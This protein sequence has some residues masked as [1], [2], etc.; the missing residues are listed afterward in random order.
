LTASSPLIA[1]AE[2]FAAAETASSEIDSFL[3]EI[4]TSFIPST[5]I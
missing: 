3:T 2:F 1:T 5:L 4:T